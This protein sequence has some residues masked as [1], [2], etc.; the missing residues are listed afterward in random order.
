MPPSILVLGPSEWARDGPD[1]P[2]PMDPLEVRRGLAGQMKRTGAPALVLEDQEM[3]DAEDDFAFFERVVK[4]NEVRTFVVY[5]PAA[6]KL[7][8]LNVEIG[9][10]LTRLSQKSLAPDAVVIL[11]E[12]RVVGIDHG[13]GVL[14]FAERGN[15]T[16]YHPSLIARGCVVRRWRTG[17]TLRRLAR[18]VAAEHRERHGLAARSGSG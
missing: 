8:G 2:V 9:H 7:H 3:T 12:E 13:K 5:W 15:R 11:A 14:T 1:R 18:A 10:L 6:A 16:R 17:A 4:E